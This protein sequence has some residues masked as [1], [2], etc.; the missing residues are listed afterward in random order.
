[1]KKRLFCGLFYLLL[2]IVVNSGCSLSAQRVDIV[3]IYSSSMNIVV[4]NIVILPEGYNSELKEKYP[5]IYLLHGYGG[6]YLSWLKVIKPELPEL[7]DKYQFI[8]VCPDGKNSWYWDSPFNKKSQ[9]E[10]YVS[11]EL[12][13]YIDEHYKTIALPRGR[14]ITGFS[15]G[16]HGALWLTMQHPEVFGGCGSMSGGVDIRP[17]PG[18]W[19]MAKA[20]GSYPDNKTLWD[21][22]TVITN[23]DKL[24]N[25]PFIFDCGE[26]DFFLNVNENLHRLLLDKEIKH[27]YITTSGGHDIQYWRKA[28]DRHFEFFSDFFYPVK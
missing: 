18:N 24:K 25:I 28:I 11:Q 8:I 6:S 4:N 17:F 16:G 20:L 1:M 2:L 27:T 26:D 10:T 22:H 9:Y 19:E 15:M 14:A 3:D 5:V 13:N 23:V 12:V 7:A 21:T